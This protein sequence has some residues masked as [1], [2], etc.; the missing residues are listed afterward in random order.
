MAGIIDLEKFTFCGKVLQSLSEM[1]M[2]DT[3]KGPALDAIHTVYNDI[4]TKT[5]LGFIGEGGFVGVKDA[6]CGSQPRAFKAATRKLTWTP[7]EWEIFTEQCYTDLENSVAV[8]SLR[9]GVDIPDLTE[10]DYVNIVLEVLDQAIKKFWYRLFW[11]NDTAAKNVSEGGI[12][13]DGIDTAY[14]DII[15]GFFKQLTVQAAANPKQR[16]TI[17][18]N[19][20]ETYAEQELTVANVQ[21]YLRK[22]VFEAPLQLRNLSDRVILVTQSVYDAYEQSLMN[23]CCLESARTTLLNGAEALKFKGIPVVALPIWD[24]IIQTAEDT[25]TKLNNPHRIVFTA[26]SVLGIGV[27]DITKFGNLEVWYDKKDKKVYFRSL[28][29]ADAKLTNPNYFVLGI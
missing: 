12:I 13:T 19:A 21:E 6:G 17:A 2:E 27:D 16:V 7:K 22:V 23:A 4:V 10:T 8:Y 5:E 24:E 26:K 3:I 29:K 1:I 28:G 20:G 9:T 11:F 18:E 25:G 15:D 14:F